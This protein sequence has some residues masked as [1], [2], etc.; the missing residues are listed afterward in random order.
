MPRSKRHEP[1][2]LKDRP[3]SAGQK[4]KGRG[5]SIMG[6]WRDGAETW[7]V[8]EKRE[9]GKAAG[10]RWGPGGW[11]GAEGRTRPAASRPAWTEAPGDPRR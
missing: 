6:C 5:V 11:G 9:P 8:R 10:A 7:R 2:A 1:W 4:Q 3:G